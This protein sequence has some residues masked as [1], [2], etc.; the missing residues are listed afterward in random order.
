MRNFKKHKEP[1]GDDTTYN[2]ASC[3]GG[4]C[5]YLTCNEARTS[6][7][8]IENKGIGIGRLWKRSIQSLSSPSSGPYEILMRS[9]FCV[10]WTSAF[11]A[12]ESQFKKLAPNDAVLQKS[13]F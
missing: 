5:I 9:L 10:N 3:S 6:P 4:D 1:C 12:H 8:N 2:K 13:N 7:K 11:I